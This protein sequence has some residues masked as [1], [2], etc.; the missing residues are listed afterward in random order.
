MELLNISLDK[1]ALVCPSCFQSARYYIY[2]KKKQIKT[3]CVDGHKYQ[4]ISFYP[5]DNF[6]VKALWSSNKECK[7]CYTKINEFI[8]ND[9]ESLLNNEDKRLGAYS[10][11]KEQITN[12]KLTHILYNF[13]LFLLNSSSFLVS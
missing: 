1:L 3:E 4:N 8:L 9:S 12:E 10:V 7:K 11:T 2:P 6:C 5:F 13:K